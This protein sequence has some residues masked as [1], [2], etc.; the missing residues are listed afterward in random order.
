MAGAFTVSSK[1]RVASCTTKQMGR[2]S[3]APAMYFR[4]M[5]IERSF[6]QRCNTRGMRR[7]HLRKHTNILK[8]LLIRLAGFNLSLVS[9][10]CSDGVPRAACSALLRVLRM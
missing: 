1:I 6:A 10:R 5:L 8:C 2:P 7:M 9:V 3:L 4:L